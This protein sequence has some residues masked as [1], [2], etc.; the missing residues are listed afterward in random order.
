VVFCIKITQSRK[1]YDFERDC[2]KVKTTEWQVQFFV[3]LIEYMG[4]Y[5]DVKSGYPPECCKADK[6]IRIFVEGGVLSG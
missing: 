1:S 3:K 2:S 5:K 4:Q 6:A